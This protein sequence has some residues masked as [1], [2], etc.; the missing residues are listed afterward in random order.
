[1][2]DIG[3]PLEIRQRRILSGEAALPDPGPDDAVL[4][5][6]LVDRR[7]G[8]PQ[9]RAPLRFRRGMIGIDDECA[10]SEMI[11]ASSSTPSRS[12]PAKP[13]IRFS[14]VS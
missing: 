7:P 8:I 13:R 10:A 3:R 4:V 5:D 1:M 12:T 9:L 14:S 6:L 2:L 11:I